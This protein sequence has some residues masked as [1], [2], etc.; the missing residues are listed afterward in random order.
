MIAAAVGALAA[1]AAI[2]E[3]PFSFDSAPGRLPKNVVALAYRVDLVPDIHGRSFAGVE[4][5]TLQVRT[6]TATIVF[7]SLNETLSEVQLDHRPVATVVSNDEQ[8]LMTVTLA[9]PAPPGR[10]TLTFTYTG[11]IESQPHGLF[12]QSFTRIGG[13][14]LL[15]ST[16]NGKHGWPAFKRRTDPLPGGRRPAACGSAQSRSRRRPSVLPHRCN[17]CR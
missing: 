12:A 1:M 16:K 17:A 2:A 7:D 10:H 5:V 11:R 15:L 9:A 8:Q 13:Q 4:A 14:G 6:A 3:A